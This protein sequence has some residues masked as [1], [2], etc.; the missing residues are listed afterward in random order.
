MQGN[1][2][3]ES[4]QNKIDAKMTKKSPK[5]ISGIRAKTCVKKEARFLKSLSDF[6]KKLR[7]QDN[8]RAC[9]A[10]NQ[11]TKVKKSSTESVQNA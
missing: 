4:V 6:I 11:H 3:T 10:R 1:I 8:F 2:S 5:S 9:S 7:T